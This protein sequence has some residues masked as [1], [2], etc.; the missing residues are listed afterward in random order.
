MNKQAPLPKYPIESVDNA[1]RLLLVLGDRGE[2]GVSEAGE[3][4]GVA[5]STAHRLLAMLGHHGFVQQDPA[6]KTY[7]AGPAL[8]QIGLAAMREIDIRAQ[9]HPSLERLVAEVGETAHLGVLQGTDVLFI[10]CVEGSRALRAGARVGQTLPAH[11]TAAGKAMLAGLGDERVDE[12]YPGEELPR[13]TGATITKR[14]GL[15]DELLRVRSDGYATNQG[16]SEA[17]LSAVAA[18]IVDRAGRVRGA[19]TVAAPDQRMHAEDLPAT[20][21]LVKDAAAEVGERLA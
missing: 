6:H 10:D 18:A 4:L 3:F 13:V 20:A 21:R 8:V 5:P 1:L 17:D 16:E 9:A 15:H 14:S 2:I 7:K 12:L 19:I 11:C